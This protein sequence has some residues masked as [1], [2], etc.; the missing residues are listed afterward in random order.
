[1]G[2]HM[3]QAVAVVVMACGLALCATTESL[4]QYLTGSAREDFIRGAVNGCM[5]EKIKDQEASVIPNS[6]FERHYC[7]CYA[8]ALADK[9]KIIDIEPENKAVTDPITKAATASCYQGMKAE[10]LRLYNAGQYRKQ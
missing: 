3:K 10:A 8:N 1:M 2:I 7:R 9:I 4:A 6:L 5:R